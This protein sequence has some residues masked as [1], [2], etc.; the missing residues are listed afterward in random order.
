MLLQKHQEVDMPLLWFVKFEPELAFGC[1]FKH[2]CRA[3]VKYKASTEPLLSH[4]ACSE[5]LYSYCTY[6]SVQVAESWWNHHNLQDTERSDFVMSS[7]THILK[8]H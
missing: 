6:H 1:M 2:T 8:Y 3:Y 4:C 5:H 7:L